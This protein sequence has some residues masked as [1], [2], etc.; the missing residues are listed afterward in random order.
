MCATSCTRGDA[1]PLAPLGTPMRE[2]I[3]LI[4]EK[5]LGCLGV[6]DADGR[7]VGIVTDG[8]LRRH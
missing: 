6:V 3:L 2:A 7:L 4:T 8:D 1:L 5:G